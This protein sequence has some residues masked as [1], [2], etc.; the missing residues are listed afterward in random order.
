MLTDT[1]L[2]PYSNFEQKKNFT[3]TLPPFPI[4]LEKLLLEPEEEDNDDKEPITEKQTTEKEGEAEKTE[5]INVE[6]KKEDDDVTQATTPANTTTTPTT[7]PIR[8]QE[9]A[10]H[11]LIDDLTKLDIDEKEEVPINQLK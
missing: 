8:K 4:F 2:R 3:R 9:R 11:Q 6:S 1:A 7:A 5:S 10:V